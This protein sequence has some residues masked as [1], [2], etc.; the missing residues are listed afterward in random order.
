MHNR[1]GKNNIYNGLKG[2]N[3][4]DRAVFCGVF[5]RITRCL[6]AA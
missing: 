4:H 6:R 1:F 3:R 2:L 5:L